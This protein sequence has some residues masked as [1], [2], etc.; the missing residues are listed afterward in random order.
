[1]FR[2][3]LVGGLLR[4]LVG[5][6]VVVVGCVAALHWAYQQLRAMWWLVVLGAVLAGAVWL[7]RRR[8]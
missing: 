1:M 7:I 4:Q 6:V 3:S 5:L 8:F 2:E